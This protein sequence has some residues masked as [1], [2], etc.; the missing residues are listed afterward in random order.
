MELLYDDPKRENVQKKSV[1][2]RLEKITISH[3]DQKFIKLLQLGGAEKE[4]EVEA[5]AMGS[6]YQNKGYSTS[7]NDS[8]HSRGGYYTSDRGKSS[9][10]KSFGKL[11]NTRAGSSL[12]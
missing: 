1:F 6:S 9:T 4:A 12:S 10:N 2:Y 5:D 8:K 11:D 3:A 7:S